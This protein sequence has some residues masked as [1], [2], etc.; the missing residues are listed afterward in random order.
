MVRTKF[1]P[2]SLEVSAASSVAYVIGVHMHQYMGHFSD[3]DS[4]N[5]NILSR[6]NVTTSEAVG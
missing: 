5:I 6:H 2:E 4:N 3:N 1:V